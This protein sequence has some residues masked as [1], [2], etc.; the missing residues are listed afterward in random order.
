MTT[1]GQGRIDIRKADQ[2][3]LTRMG[4]LDSKHSF[5]FGPHYDP[6]NVGH[7]LLIVNNDDMVRPGTG[8]MT[9]PHQDMEIVTWVLDGELEHKDS[10]GN[11]GII[12]P[13]LAQRMSAGTGIYHSEMNPSGEKPVHFIQMWVPPDTERIKP[14]YEQLDVNR[15]LE[16]GGLVPIASG[17]GHHAA[18]SIRQ[19]GA[20]LWGGRLKPGESVTIPQAP[21]AHLYVAGGAVEL[22][23][24][25][26]LKAGDAARLTAAGPLRMTADAASGAQVLIWESDRAVNTE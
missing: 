25:G 14:G 23:G 10:E 24:A 13:G 8:F 9:H 18:I 1:R 15:E 19:K 21:Y 22:E 4:W 12:Y 2:R 6:D 7:G 3:F 5:S 17:K 16:Q 20:V 11:K 26:V